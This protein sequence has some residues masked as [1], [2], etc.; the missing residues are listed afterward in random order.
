MGRWVSHISR[1]LLVG[2]QGAGEQPSEAGAEQEG[3][4][5]GE[6]GGQ[7][8][9]DRGRSGGA[10]GLEDAEGEADGESEDG[11]DPQGGADLLVLLRLHNAGEV[12]DLAD[13]DVEP[14]G[15]QVLLLVGGEDIV[16]VAVDAGGAQP[17]DGAEAGSPVLEG[18]EVAG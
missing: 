7:R 11:D 14:V 12:A 13:D 4:G 17:V 1:H 10:D 6:R 3:D 18:G 2:S 16:G 9:E 15:E 8:D 5:R